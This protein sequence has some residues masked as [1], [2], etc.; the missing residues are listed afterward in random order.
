VGVAG[1]VFRI[2]DKPGIES[3]E[4][5]LVDQ[6]GGINAGEGLCAVKQGL[7]EGGAVFGLGTGGAVEGD[8]GGEGLLGA[9]AGVDAGQPLQAAEHDAGGGDDEDGEG[10]LGHDEQAGDAEAV[11]CSED[12]AGVGAEGVLDVAAS[13]LEGGDEAGEDSGNE[14]DGGGKEE[15]IAMEG[16]VGE[17]RRVWRQD[18]LEGVEAERGEQYAEGAG[19]AG[20]D[21]A[22]GEHLP[23]EA[24]GVCSE[25]GTE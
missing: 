22:L 19:E 3:G 9:E 13:G 10:D 8:L 1:V 23:D 2:E 12:V 25:G 7:K 4:G 5:E 18:E 20:E 6:G 15:D 11:G 16:E 17:P 21:S 24:S 14:G